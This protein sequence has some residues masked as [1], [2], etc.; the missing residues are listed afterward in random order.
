M[1]EES[2][3]E[4]DA[5]TYRSLIAGPYRR[6][7]FGRGHSVKSGGARDPTIILLLVSLPFFGVFF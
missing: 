5:P 7:L 6:K 2:E 1:R 3:V 4:F